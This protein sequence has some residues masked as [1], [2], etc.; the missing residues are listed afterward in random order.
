M[1]SANFKILY[2]RSSII[3]LFS[4]VTMLQI[5]SFPGQFAHMRRVG[6]IELLFEIWLTLLLA[7]WLFAAQFALLCLWKIV[8]QISLNSIYSNSALKWLDRLVQAFKY[9]LITAITVFIS[10]A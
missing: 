1:I 6:S 10:I 3:L 8:G 4:I 2:A 7:I 5:F 9:A